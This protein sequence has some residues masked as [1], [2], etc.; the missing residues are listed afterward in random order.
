[1]IQDILTL[2]QKEWKEVVFHRGGGRQSWVSM[3]ILVGLVGIYLPYVNGAAWLQEPTALLAWAWVPLFMTIGLVADAFAGERERHTLETLLATRLS[4][5]AILLG[6]IAA[7]VLYAW[8]ISLACALV[9]AAT[10]NVAFPGDGLQ[11]YN[12]GMFFGGVAAVLLIAI[13]ISSIGVFVS[14]KAG[15]VRQAYQ[16]LSLS[17][18]AIWFIPFILLQTFPAQVQDFFIRVG[19]VLDAKLPLIIAGFFGVLVVADVVMLLFAKKRF[20][21]T[22]LILE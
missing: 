11:F 10:I 9:G 8:D 1:M 12:T 18:M 15:T 22:R 19:P 17:I 21:R 7:S 20:Q 4:D 14:L 13:F 3:A 16:K 6:K 2:I 5:T